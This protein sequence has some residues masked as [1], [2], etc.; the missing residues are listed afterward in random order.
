MDMIS[1][2]NINPSRIQKQ[3]WK[4]KVLHMAVHEAEIEMGN[5]VPERAKITSTSLISFGSS[6][7]WLLEEDSWDGLC[8]RMLST[9]SKDNFFKHQNMTWMRKTIGPTYPKQQ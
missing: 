1:G 7:C 5:N 9:V 3:V 2:Q 6:H 4:V 8:F